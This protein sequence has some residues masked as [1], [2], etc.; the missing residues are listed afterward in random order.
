[1]TSQIT[2]SEIKTAIRSY[3]PDASVLL[4]GSR[5]RKE[6][7]TSSDYDLLIISDTALD[8]ID[9]MTC[10]KQI[11]KQLTIQFEQPFDIILQT[12]GEWQQKKDLVG[13]ISYYATREGVEI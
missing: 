7:H 11:R 1:M 10:E 6:E 5:V 4:F 2:L 12:R 9:K 13:H 3:L 8:R